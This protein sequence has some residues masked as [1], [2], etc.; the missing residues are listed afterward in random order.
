MVHC[1]A[2]CILDDMEVFA[3]PNPGSRAIRLIARPP[4]PVP[5]FLIHGQLHRYTI[6]SLR[7]L[8]LD[9]FGLTSRIRP[10]SSNTASCNE[11]KVEASKTTNTNGS[12]FRYRPPKYLVEDDFTPRAETPG[13]S[14]PSYHVHTSLSWD[15]RQVC[16]NR[17]LAHFLTTNH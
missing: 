5:R 1:A 14:R 4:S 11:A 13:I 6:L 12:S 3:F 17:C 7:T 9:F 10:E 8:Q 15:T 2:Q 16:T